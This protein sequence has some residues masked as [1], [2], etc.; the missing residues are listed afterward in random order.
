MFAKK[1]AL[2]IG[3]TLFSLTF[4]SSITQ[5]ADSSNVLAEKAAAAGCKQFT[6]SMTINDAFLNLSKTAQTKAKMSDAVAAETKAMGSA[7]AS[8]KSAAKQ[9]KQWKNI[10]DKLDTVIHTDKADAYTKS[11]A[12]VLAACTSLAKTIKK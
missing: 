4:S 6:L 11:F 7:L 2:V 5:A 12:F 10:A 3:L 8:F 1:Y 9:D